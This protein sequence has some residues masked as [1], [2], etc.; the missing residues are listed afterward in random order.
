MKPVL[1][2]RQNTARCKNR[3]EGT[4]QSTPHTSCPHHDGLANFVL[5]IASPPPPLRIKPAM[6]ENSIGQSP[7]L[8][9]CSCRTRGR[10]ALLRLTRAPLRPSNHNPIAS[11]FRHGA[12]GSR[13][14][15]GSRKPR[16]NISVA[17]RCRCRS[18]RCCCRPGDALVG[19]LVAGAI[20][21]ETA[22]EIDGSGAAARLRLAG[23]PPGLSAS[24]LPIGRRPRES[25]D[26]FS[27]L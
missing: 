22:E 6:K 13:R 10:R 11:G 25:G 23:G 26:I 9:V 27:Q 3:Q 7:S 14:S 21:L 16:E 18:R 8:T 1:C 17:G 12:R 15:N 4:E 2:T 24:V 5:S 20:E 19:V